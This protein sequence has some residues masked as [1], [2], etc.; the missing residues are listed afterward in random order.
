MLGRLLLVGVILLGFVAAG[1]S[2]GDE[3]DYNGETAK[4]K[5]A[6]KPGAAPA[7]KKGGPGL[8]AEP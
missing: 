5:D 6:D 4:F 3:G 2:G 7:G 8:V 1:C